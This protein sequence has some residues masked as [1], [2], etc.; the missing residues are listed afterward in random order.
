MFTADQIAAKGFTNVVIIDAPTGALERLSKALDKAKAENRGTKSIED[1][2]VTFFNADSPYPGTRN[3]QTYAL[4]E[5]PSGGEPLISGY[6]NWRPQGPPGEPGV[7]L[8]DCYTVAN[9]INALK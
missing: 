2:P 8:Y 4:V 9:E 5:S 3:I 7:E 6:V 1:V